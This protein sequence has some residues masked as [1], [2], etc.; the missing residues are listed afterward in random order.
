MRSSQGRRPRW[1]RGQTFL[2]LP[3]VFLAGTAAAVT[4]GWLGP[5]AA[6]ATAAAAQSTAEDAA[7]VSLPVPAA[8][9]PDGS[10]AAVVGAGNAVVVDDRATG[11]PVRSLSRTSNRVYALAFSPDGSLLATGGDGR[12][13]RVWNARTGA[14]LDEAHEPEAAKGN[15]GG[16]SAIAGIAFG[17][18]GAELALVD[19]GDRTLLVYT[20]D[21]STSK[22]T[23]RAK[24]DTEVPLYSIAMSPQG[25]WIAGGADGRLR[26][27]DA[28][29]RLTGTTAPLHNGVIRAIQVG[30]LGGYLATGGDDAMLRVWDLAGARTSGG[31]VTLPPSDSFAAVKPL[32]GLAFSGGTSSKILLSIDNV[33]RVRD[34]PYGLTPVA[35]V[36]TPPAP[37]PTPTPTPTPPPP[38]PTPT[39]T[40]TP[41]TVRPTP[42]PRPTPPPNVSRLTPGDMNPNAAPLHK[43]VGAHTDYVNS[44]A[45]SPD[46]RQLASGSRDKTVRLWDTAS[47]RSHGTLGRHEGYVSEVAFSPNGKFLLSCGWDDRIKL[48]DLASKK[49]VSGARFRGHTGFVL[50]AEF[51]PDGQYIASGSND[52]TARLWPVL[53]RVPDR[54]SARKPDAISSVSFSPDG[55]LIAGG[56]LDGRVYLFNAK[57]LAP[58]RTLTAAPYRP[59]LNVLFAGN[60][61]VVGVCKDGYVRIWNPRTGTLGATLQAN[62]QDVFSVAYDRQRGLLATGGSDQKISLWA[63]PAGNTAGLITRPLVQLT[64]HDS[65]VRALA[66]SA[67][68]T[69]LASGSWNGDIYLWRVADFFAR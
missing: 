6:P 3:I 60:D 57:T 42:R 33:G 34:W 38:T 20:V 30:P 25:G 12:T 43:I 8:L 61:R 46:G 32:R 48:W 41:V 68:G 21:P 13:I 22:L 11:L 40:P 7:T 55:T 4:A 47:G 31:T 65:T 24:A 19:P 67:D 37:T 5:Y 69:T 44:V 16:R 9:S 64:G 15:S 2:A 56:C 36:P 17:A 50:S 35:A 49:D 51:S 10:L 18:L 54:K 14:R 63:I 66:F 39:P 29:L 28:S 59:V 26:F 27:Y 23:F 62:G 58:V 45:F 1:D 52:K 53:L